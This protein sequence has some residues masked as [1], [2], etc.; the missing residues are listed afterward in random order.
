MKF[1]THFKFVIEALK[2]A[3]RRTKELLTM[4]YFARVN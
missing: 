3:Y 2:R 1:T 4:I